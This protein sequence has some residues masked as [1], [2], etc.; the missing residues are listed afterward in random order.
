[1]EA[2]HEPR[3]GELIT[4]IGDDVKTIATGEFELARAKLGDYLSQT[5]MRAAAM[6]VGAFVAVVGFAMLCVVV[7]V[8]LAPLIQALWLRLLLMACVYLVIGGGAAY[9]F[10]RTLSRPPDLDREV[11]QVG[12]TI[13]KISAGLQ[14]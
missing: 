6:V 14:H 11:A 3:V 7:V 2:S 12:H 5:V 13:D 1:M 4:H 8:A 10:A 9:G